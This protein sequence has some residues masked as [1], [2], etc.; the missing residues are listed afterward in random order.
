MCAGGCYICPLRATR[1]QA[2]ACVMARASEKI[3]APSTAPVSFVILPILASACGQCQR[4]AARVGHRAAAGQCV[5]SAGGRD[6]AV[7]P[8]PRRSRGVERRGA[9]WQWLASRLARGPAGGWLRLSTEPPGCSTRRVTLLLAGVETRHPPATGH[10][11]RVTR[12]GPRAN[13]RR[14]VR[15]QTRGGGAGWPPRLAWPG[16]G[17]C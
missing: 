3:Y 5:L 2:L 8:V 4:R 12:H 13:C 6:G 11:S 9:C 16:D 1:D 10:W 14:V 7:W 17:R 15:P